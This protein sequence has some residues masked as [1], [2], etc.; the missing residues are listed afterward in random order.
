MGCSEVGFR[1]FTMEFEMFRSALG[2]IGTAYRLQAFFERRAAGA[3]A[4]TSEST[5]QIT[6]GSPIAG[7]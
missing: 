2:T 4:E 1:A 6:Q 7:C 3:R 5:R